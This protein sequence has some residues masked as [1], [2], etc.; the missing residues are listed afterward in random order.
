MTLNLS[1]LG[2]KHTS[3]K[4]E[5]A[6]TEAILLSRVSSKDQEENYSLDAQEERLRNYCALKG[7]EVIAV[8][9]F[10][11][12]STRGNRPKFSD[13][14]KQIK[15]RKKPIAIICDKVDRLQ[16]GFKETPMLEELRV[17]GKAELHFISNGNLV[18]HK[19][20]TSQELLQYNFYVLLAKNYTDCI[21]ENVNRAHEQMVREGKAMGLAPLGYLNVRD[22]QT[23]VANI[24]LDEDRYH[25]VRRIFEYYS[26]GLYSLSELVQLTK[27]WGLNNKGKAHKPLCKCQ[28]EKILKNVFYCGYAKRIDEYY[29]HCYPKI[30]S[31]EL[32]MK[33][34][35]V[36]QSRNKHFTKMTKH[37]TVFK[38][39]IKCAN[40]GCTVTPDPKK[41]GRYIY[42]KPNSKKGCNCKQIN[43]NVA[44]DMVSRVFKS[45][46]MSEEALQPY[47]EAL[48]T[49]FKESD[50]IQAKEKLAYTKQL[51]VLK[52]RLDRLKKVYLDGDFTRDEYLAE[53][54]CIE[55]EEQTL[56]KRIESLSTDSKDVVI[57]LEYLLDL[58]SR[59]NSLYESSRIDKKRRILN[60]VFSNFWLNGQNLSYELKRPFDIFIK[61]S[62]RLLNWA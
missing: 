1:H 24:I 11:E 21:S 52:T 45:M 31:M 43:E 39:L 13:M 33:C 16:R 57:T 5:Q 51:T 44:N 36:R 46:S 55:M 28:I 54:Q 10:A 56:E 30:V 29:E 15:S 59:A 53:K 49:R 8:C 20:S 61:R 58:V 62:N 7:F 50:D 2:I 48:R 34:V 27:E 14:M 37:E 38:G 26:T 40:C 41:G 22:P 9:S 32:F 35:A 3:K 17:S 47:V 25:K 60:L 4:A 42:L 19:D 18:I 23:K 12:S 6:I